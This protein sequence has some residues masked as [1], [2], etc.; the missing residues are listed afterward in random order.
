MIAQEFAAFVGL[1]S[2]GQQIFGASPYY[3]ALF[4]DKNKNTPDFESA[5]KTKYTKL[6][7]LYP[8]QNYHVTVSCDTVEC[9]DRNGQNLFAWTS[10]TAKVISLCP[11]W[12]DD[13]KKAKAA[14]VL[15]RCQPDSPDARKWNK[16]SQF[17][18]TKGCLF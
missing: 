18:K 10:A 1:A 4:S 14:D 16:L 17:K 8:D 13:I 15:T 2:A 9:V 11:S 7:G 3:Q 12:F 6:A 5:V